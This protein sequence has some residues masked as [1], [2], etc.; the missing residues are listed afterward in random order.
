MVSLLF[1]PS[2]SLFPFAMLCIHSLFCRLV[3][4]C[5][6]GLE[7]VTCTLKSTRRSNQ[8]DKGLCC[9]PTIIAKSTWNTKQFALCHCIFQFFSRIHLFPHPLPFET[10][11]IIQKNRVAEKIV[12]PNLLRRFVA[13]QHCSK[14]GGRGMAEF[15]LEN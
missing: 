13:N 5:A 6:C 8:K 9:L 3:N 14:G 10:M 1:S 12:L 2:R 11:L 7:R 4:Q 15:S